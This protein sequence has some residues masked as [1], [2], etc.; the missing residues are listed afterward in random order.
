MAKEA[1]ISVNFDIRTCP[2]SDFYEKFKRKQRKIT[3]ILIR[4]LG[5]IKET[6]Y[7]K[8]FYPETS[9]PWYG[10]RN[11]SRELIVTINDK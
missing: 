10:S 3:A 4:E 11:L 2:F 1:S 8:Y 6:N 5:T 9:K 7:F